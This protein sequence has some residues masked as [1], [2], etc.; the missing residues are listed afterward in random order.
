MR[1]ISDL[2]LAVGFG[3]STAEHVAEVAQIAEGVVVG[4]AIVRCIEQNATGNLPERLEEF[5]RSLTA[6][7]RN[8]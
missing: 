4:S 6:P 5:T 7:L 3:I 1:E 8:R 2:P